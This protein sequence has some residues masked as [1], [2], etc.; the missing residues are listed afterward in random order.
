M[1]L[2]KCRH[3]RHFFYAEFDVAMIDSNVKDLVHRHKIRTF[4]AH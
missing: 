3:S 1:T 2:K 4:D